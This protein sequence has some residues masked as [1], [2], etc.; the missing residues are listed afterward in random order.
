MSEVEFAEVYHREGKDR[1]RY[2]QTGMALTDEIARA[3]EVVKKKYPQVRVRDFGSIAHLA[4]E[5][6]VSEAVLSITPF[7]PSK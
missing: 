4:V 6:V 1:E 2:T 7:K 3:L 5:D